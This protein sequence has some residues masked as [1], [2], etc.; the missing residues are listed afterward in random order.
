MD[1][2]D[3]PKRWSACLPVGRA[4]W[5]FGTMGPKLRTEGPKEGRIRQRPA[6]VGTKASRAHKTFDQFFPFAGSI[7]FKIPATSQTLPPQRPPAPRPSVALDDAPRAPCRSKHMLRVT[8]PRRVGL[9][10]GGGPPRCES[11]RVS[12]HGR[13]VCD[14]AS[15]RGVRRRHLENR[16]GLR[17]A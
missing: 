2:F 12:V 8:A 1:R 15:A 14:W 11:R 5:F 13:R 17:Y 7:Q 9:T 6:R 4:G 3:V 10:S 16:V